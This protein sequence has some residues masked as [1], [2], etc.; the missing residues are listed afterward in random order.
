MRAHPTPGPRSCFEGAFLQMARYKIAVLV[1]YWLDTVP[2]QRFRW[3]QWLPHLEA[4]GLDVELL[5]FLTPAITAA[6]ARGAG[7]RATLLALRRYLP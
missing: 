1:P 4:N 7:L 2:S 3:E 6:R 5:P